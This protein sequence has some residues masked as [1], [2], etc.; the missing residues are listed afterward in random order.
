MEEAGE[1][2]SGERREQVNAPPPSVAQRP[3]VVDLKASRRRGDAK[4]QRVTVAA[5]S[6]EALHGVPSAEPL[7]RIPSVKGRDGRPECDR[8]HGDVRADG[9]GRPH[10]KS[11]HVDG[12]LYA[13]R[14]P[15]GSDRETHGIAG[16]EG[17]PRLIWRPSSSGYS[18][19]WFLTPRSLQR[20]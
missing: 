15:P 12:N 3:D 13:H 9:V 20:C 2:P 10:L 5:E 7:C 11:V 4:A 1:A 6:L 19:S 8:A 16:V 14:A 18:T 17:L